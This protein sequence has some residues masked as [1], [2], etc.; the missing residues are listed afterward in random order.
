MNFKEFQPLIQVKMQPVY[1]GYRKAVLKHIKTRRKEHAF[2]PIDETIVEVL[3]RYYADWLYLEEY[4]SQ[5]PKQLAQC[6]DA[7]NKLVG[8]MRELWKDLIL[9]PRARR[10][11]MNDLKQELEKDEKVKEFLSKLMGSDT[12]Q[13]P[14]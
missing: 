2:E 5:D 11:I 9:T 4:A 8:T 14:G 13:R 7:M 3:A 10:Q 6:T 1:E 12:A